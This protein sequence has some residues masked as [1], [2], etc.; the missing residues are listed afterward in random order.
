MDKTIYNYLTDTVV[1]FGDVSASYE[2]IIDL[3]D[4]YMFRGFMFYSSLDQPVSIKFENTGAKGDW[5][6]WNS[7]ATY[8]IGSIVQASSG[9]AYQSLQNANIDKEPS[10]NPS[11]WK[12]FSIELNVPVVVGGWKQ[13]QDR[14]RHNNKIQLKH[15]GA[16]PT[17]GFLK[18]ICWR[19]E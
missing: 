4:K 5:Q 2:T 19:A 13:A 17:A 15:L 3:G 8:E 6:I 1:D 12:I 16:A 11:W 7:S 18:M 14:F 10:A 9:T